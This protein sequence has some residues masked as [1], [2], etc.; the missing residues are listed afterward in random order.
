MMRTSEASVSEADE[1]KEPYF[2]HN[3]KSDLRAPW[4]K[5]DRSHSNRTLSPTDRAEFT[6]VQE[7]SLQ[8]AVAKK[9]RSFLQLCRQY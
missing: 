4:P 3:P 6:R 5:E 2:L 1:K 8:T 9:G 7:H